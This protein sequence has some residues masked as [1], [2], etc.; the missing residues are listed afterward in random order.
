MI[1]AFPKL[2]THPSRKLGSMVHGN[3]F[4]SEKA[5]QDPESRIGINAERR[6]LQNQEEARF[7]VHISCVDARKPL[8]L[9]SIPATVPLM[10]SSRSRIEC[11][12]FLVCS[13]RNL[14]FEAVTG[15][16]A[17]RQTG[18]VSDALEVSDA[19][20]LHHAV[21]SLPPPKKQAMLLQARK[22][23]GPVRTR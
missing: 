7:W 20:S 4:S 1:D 23:L 14:S 8:G 15:F 6:T 11:Q 16:V 2:N 9:D 13:A 12:V 19:G 10:P 21:Q 18:R 3:V 17:R 5:S 22:R